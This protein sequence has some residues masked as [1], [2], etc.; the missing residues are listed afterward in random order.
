[1]STSS[2]RQVNPCCSRQ[3][4]GRRRLDEHG[5]VF[6]QHMAFLTIGQ[7][8]APNPAKLHFYDHVYECARL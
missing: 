1:M 3:L 8:M 6:G 4:A 5:I 7:H 2:V